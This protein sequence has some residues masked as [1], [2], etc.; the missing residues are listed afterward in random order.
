MQKKI[1]I[2]ILLV[3]IASIFGCDKDNKKDELVP[4]SVQLK[5]IHQ[6]QFAGHYIAEEKGF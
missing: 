5:W 1:T 4:V 3:C 2:F 6:A